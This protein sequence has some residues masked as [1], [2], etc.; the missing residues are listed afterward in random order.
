MI[1]LFFFPCPLTP[2]AS[3]II[4]QRKQGYLRGAAGLVCDSGYPEVESER[5][6]SSPRLTLTS[7]FL[8]KDYYE[9]GE[10]QL[11]ATST[12]IKRKE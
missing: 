4:L 3:G 8:R 10:D 1:P 11:F 12:R 2:I 9:A 6:I 7:G 5:R